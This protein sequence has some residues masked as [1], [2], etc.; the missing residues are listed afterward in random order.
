MSIKTFEKP[1]RRLFPLILPPLFKLKYIKQGGAVSYQKNTSKPDFRPYRYKNA[2]MEFYCPLCRVPRAITVSHR[3]TSK[4]YIQ[5]IL[6]TIVTTA[7]L[8]P[9]MDGR[10]VFSFFIYLGAFE[11]VRRV[12]F[13]KEVSCPHCGFD[14]GWYKKDVKVARRLVS[15]FWQDRGSDEESADSQAQEQ[16]PGSQ[17]NSDFQESNLTA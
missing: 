5:I 13:R 1:F 7:S 10:G 8:W 4:N 9:L 14:A 2:A 16:I 17:S 12:L 3:L 6:L 15:E 11:G